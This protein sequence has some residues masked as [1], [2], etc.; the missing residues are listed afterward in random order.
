MPSRKIKIPASH[1]DPWYEADEQYE[2]LVITGHP[3]PPP[4]TLVTLSKAQKEIK[5]LK[6][7]LQIARDDQVATLLKLDE[8]QKH[9]N[10]LQKTNEDW[11]ETAA[12]VCSSRV[13]KQD[14]EPDD[15]AKWVDE[16][17]PPF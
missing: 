9:I 4:V 12:Q 17:Y 6:D 13:S 3:T 2:P 10:H 5:K 14:L 1:K 7:E 11:Q 15:L 8:A 16:N